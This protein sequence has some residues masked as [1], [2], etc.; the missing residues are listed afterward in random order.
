MYWGAPAAPEPLEA[1]LL[2]GSIDWRVKPEYKCVTCGRGQHAVQLQAAR[3]VPAVQ[4]QHHPAALH[5]CKHPPAGVGGE[6]QPW[7][8]SGCQL[9]YA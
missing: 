6:W 4:P 7:T 8:A 5:L 3:A 9:L 1:M 2:P